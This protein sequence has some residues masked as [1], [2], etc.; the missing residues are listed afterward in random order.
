MRRTTPATRTFHAL[1]ALGIATAALLI[2]PSPGAAAPEPAGQVD[3]EADVDGDGVAN[4]V[5]LHQVA[6]GTQL[7]R[8]GMPEEFVDARIGVDD[9]VRL[10]L[11]A[12]RPVDVNGDGRDE[13][14]LAV[15]VGAN[16]TTFEVW[17]Y[18]DDRLH[19]VS[20]QDGAT[21]QLHEGGGVSAISGYG[22]APPQPGGSGRQLY[23]VQAR[24]DDAASSDG[25]PR[26]DGTV[27]TQNVTGGVARPA[28]TVPLH[29]VTRD[30]PRVWTD[31][32]T[33]APV[34]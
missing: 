34:E 19:A 12:P 31:P 33:C 24:L 25:T 30:D 4:P 5:T 28:S 15:A 9:S 13:L 26:Y 14:V 22:C 7:L 8:I 27:V 20:T 16:T 10:P 11:I 2:A 17:S 21:W 1:S 3:T 32:G 6:P 18:D 23:D 29:D